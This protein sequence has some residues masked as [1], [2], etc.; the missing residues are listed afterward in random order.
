MVIQTDNSAASSS[1][2]QPYPH[3]NASGQRQHLYGK[4]RLRPWRDLVDGSRINCFDKQP[5]AGRPTYPQSIRY[6]TVARGLWSA[7]T[8]EDLSRIEND[9][10]PAF[11]IL[12]SDAHPTLTTGQRDALAR[13][14]SSFWRRN[15]AWLARQPRLLATEAAR[16]LAEIRAAPDFT[17]EEKSIIEEEAANLLETPPARPL[18]LDFMVRT[19]SHM[20]WTILCSRRGFFLTGDSPVIISPDDILISPRTELVMPISPERALVCN[21]GMHLGQLSTFAASP[22]AV[23]EVNRRIAHG[24]VRRIY[25]NAP[26]DPAWVRRLLRD[27][28]PTRTIHPDRSTRIPSF[29]RKEYA[30][31]VRQFPQFRTAETRKLLD[32]FRNAAR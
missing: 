2:G 3:H 28:R 15:R 23:R 14:I 4:A 1:R 25:S 21:W 19:F 27:L 30:E 18:P 22:G 32:S 26:L 29:I 12:S 16:L 31:S 24:A 13:C 5:G 8:E 17:P 20:S 11:D 10:N 9:A 6:A 7:T